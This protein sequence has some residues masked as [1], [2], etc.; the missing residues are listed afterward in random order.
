MENTA[1][2]GYYKALGMA[3]AGVL[4]QHCRGANLIGY[5]LERFLAFGMHE[6]LGVGHLFLQSEYLLYG[7]AFMHMA[8][9]CGRDRRL[10]FRQPAES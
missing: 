1:L 4:Q 5:G 3:V 2:R 8:G 7:E 10:S 6:D 9:D